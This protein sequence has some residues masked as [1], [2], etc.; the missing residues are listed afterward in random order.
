MYFGRIPSKL[1]R[2]NL[3][4]FDM[5]VKNLVT[6]VLLTGIPESKNKFICPRKFEILL[7]RNF[8]GASAV[9]KWNRNENFIALFFKREIVR[10]R[11]CERENDRNN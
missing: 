9:Y 1:R 4:Y 3:S 5:G 7:R 10:E 11:V 2:I 6:H 8:D